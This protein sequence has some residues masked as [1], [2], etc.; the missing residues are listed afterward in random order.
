MIADQPGQINRMLDH[1][2]AVGIHFSLPRGMAVQ[3]VM[4]AIQP[5]KSPTF[6]KGKS[7][8]WRSLFTDQHKKLFK[9]VTGELLTVLGYEKDGGW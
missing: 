3:K 2:E 1:L 7:G 8:E 9:Q 4:E 5:R 6:R